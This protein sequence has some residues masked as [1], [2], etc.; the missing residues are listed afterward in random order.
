MKI[1][2]KAAA[3]LVL[4]IS[5]TACA[6]TNVAKPS[7]AAGYTFRHDDFDFRYAWKTS[8]SGEGLRIDGLIKNIRYPQIEDLDVTVSLL[9]KGRDV[10][11]EGVSFPVPQLMNKND[12]RSFD[13]VFKD[14]NPSEVD[15]LRFRVGYRASDGGTLGII[16]KSSFTVSAA[17]GAIVGTT[18]KPV[19][20]W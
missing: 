19:D 17:T 9:N 16:W 5:L 15:Q 14:V 11:S 2:L 7:P 13:V 10:I 12:Y 8:R 3:A 6:S 1:L 4:S 18:E 20:E